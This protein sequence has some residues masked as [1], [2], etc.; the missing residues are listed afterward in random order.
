MKLAGVIYLYEISQPRGAIN[1]E[2]LGMLRGTVRN[3]V[4]ATT[5]WGN[6]VE[7]VE[8][9]RENELSSQWQFSLARFNRSA[10][11]AWRIVD[12]IL[13]NKP[14]DPRELLESLINCL[15]SENTKVGRG[16]KPQGKMFKMFF[17]K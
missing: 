9:E 7:D 6:T 15:E 2:L 12:Q 4:V 16:S 14:D 17:R 13:D 8:C 10:E 5:K 3:I 1:R 11:S